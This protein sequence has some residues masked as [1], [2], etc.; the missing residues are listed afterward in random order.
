MFTASPALS[1]HVASATVQGQLQCRSALVGQVPYHHRHRIDHSDH[2]TVCLITTGKHHAV[3][4]LVARCLSR[5]T[6]TSHTTSQ[7]KWEGAVAHSWFTSIM[8]TQLS[9]C[10]DVHTPMRTACMQHVAGATLPCHRYGAIHAGCVR[11][12]R[13]FDSKHPALAK[14]EQSYTPQPSAQH[15]AAVSL[16]PAAAATAATSCRRGRCRARRRWA[17]LGV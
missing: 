15:A 4:L 17:A 16:G 5:Y 2:V 10:S 14:A 13:T 3:T 1:R 11:P 6:A 12:L 9:L 7:T 8:Y